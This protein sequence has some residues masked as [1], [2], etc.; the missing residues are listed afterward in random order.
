MHGRFQQ[1][2]RHQNPYKDIASVDKITELLEQEIVSMKKLNSDLDKLM[3]TK[4]QKKQK[5]TQIHRTTT[6]KRVGTSTYA[7]RQASKRA[8]MQTQEAHCDSYRYPWQAPDT[9]TC[10][11]GKTRVRVNVGTRS[12]GWDCAADLHLS[13]FTGDDV[14]SIGDMDSISILPTTIDTDTRFDDLFPSATHVQQWNNLDSE[15]GAKLKLYHQCQQNICD[16]RQ[17]KKLLMKKLNQ[18]Q[19]PTMAK[20]KKKSPRK[21]RKNTRAPKTNKRQTRKSKSDLSIEAIVLARTLFLRRF[22]HNFRITVRALRKTLFTSTPEMEAIR[23]EIII[24]DPLGG[25]EEERV[26]R[27]LTAPRRNAISHACLSLI[28]SVQKSPATKGV[29]VALCAFMLFVLVGKTHREIFQP[30]GVLS[31]VY[32]HQKHHDVNFSVAQATELAKNL[33]GDEFDERTRRFIIIFWPLVTTLRNNFLGFMNVVGKSFTYVVESNT[34]TDMKA[35]FFAVAEIMTGAL[36]GFK[37]LLPSFLTLKNGVVEFMVLVSAIAHMIRMYTTTVAQVRDHFY[38]IKNDTEEL[39]DM[40]PENNLKQKIKSIDPAAEF[41]KIINY[42][43]DN[44]NS[45]EI[46]QPSLMDQ[47]AGPSG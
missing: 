35:G 28:E 41:S 16:L 42:N 25:T 20:I 18:K 23:Q 31:R 5:S 17:Q 12:E 7:D 47:L 45:D 37:A 13:E 26:V 10:A 36:N 40:I 21:Q 29:I 2:F 32:W 1:S 27:Q 34:I 11:P 9:C 4:K 15:Y 33:S 46:Q 3:E 39:V 22:P 8:R 19:T 30:L 43:F 38:S 14:N 44:L 24:S 6:G